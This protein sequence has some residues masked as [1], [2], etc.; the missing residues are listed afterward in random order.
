MYGIPLYA[1]R[2]TLDESAMR[3]GRLTRVHSFEGGDTLAFRGVRVQTFPTPHD[4]AESV[5][6]VVTTG[7][8]RLGILT[9]L[10]H[11][12][13]GLQEVVASL[14][15]VFIESNYDDDML[16]SGPYP[17][18]LKDRIRSPH[19]HISNEESAAL[20]RACAGGRLRWACLAHLSETNNDPAVALRTHRRIWAKG[21]P[22]YVASRYRP[23][24]PFEL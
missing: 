21:F 9:D 6:F 19:G 17:P 15:G 20:M 1:T 24:G 11:V 13:K 7:R 5:A 2:G 12:F 14:D 23:T 4:G 18:F 3:I 8:K 16:A 22:L 10:G